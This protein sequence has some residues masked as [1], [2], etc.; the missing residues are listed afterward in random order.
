MNRIRRHRALRCFLVAAE[1]G[2]PLRQVMC[3]GDDQI[4]AALALVLK[5][6]R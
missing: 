1:L 5:G 2:A 3:W 4:S 6:G